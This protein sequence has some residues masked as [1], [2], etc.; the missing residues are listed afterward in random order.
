MRDS[1]LEGD[2][3]SDIPSPIATAAPI[4]SN[5][6]IPITASSAPNVRRMR[7][8]VKMR[9]TTTAVEM[10][11]ARLRIE[12]MKVTW[13]CPSRAWLTFVGP[14]PPMFDIV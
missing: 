10:T 3:K 8:R 11:V 1:R 9:R 6:A 14:D 2:L 5:C 4:V 7:E 13:D 12:T